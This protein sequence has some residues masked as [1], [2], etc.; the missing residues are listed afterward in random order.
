MVTLAYN[1]A[2]LTVHWAESPAEME[3]IEKHTGPL[4]DFLQ[5]SRSPAGG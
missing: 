5:R 3:L 4:A 2:P 1:R